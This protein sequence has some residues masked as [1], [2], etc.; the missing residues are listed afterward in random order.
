ME[1]AISFFSS[2]FPSGVLGEI[3]KQEYLEENKDYLTG[4]ISR[5]DDITILRYYNITLGTA[6]SDGSSRD[7]PSNRYSA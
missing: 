7:D 6:L 2:S 5:L 3:I 4:A 1:D